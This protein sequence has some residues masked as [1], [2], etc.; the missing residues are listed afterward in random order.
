MTQPR[1]LTCYDYV[2]V[3]YDRVSDLLGSD[4]APLF[5][6]ATVA[7]ARRAGTLVASLHVSVGPIEV[8]ADIKFDVRRVTDKV[9][10]LGDRSTIVDLSWTAARGAAF[11]PV[12]DATLAVFPLSPTETQLDLVGHYRPPLGVVGNAIDAIVGHRIARAS[13]Q[14]FVQEVARQ[15]E[16]ELG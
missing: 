6:R 14:R 5:Q 8:A 15:I 16:A 7:A 2:T 3:R 4:A 13:V 9:T 11:F 10:A 1:E 12:M